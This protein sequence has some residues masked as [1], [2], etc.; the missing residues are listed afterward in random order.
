MARKKKFDYFNAFVQISAHAVTYAEEMVKWLEY[1]YEEG[2]S[3]KVGKVEGSLKAYEKFHAIEEASDEITHEIASNLVTEFV[4]PI[5]REDILTL[6]S[7][8][9]SV[10]DHVDEVLQRMYMYNVKNVSR[11]VVDMANIVLEAT[12]ALH[13]ACERFTDYKQPGALR[14]WIVK[15]NDYEDAGDHAYIRSMHELY[16]RAEESDDPN[17]KIDAFGMGGVLSALENCCDSAED[18]GDTMLMVIMKNS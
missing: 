6:A 3:G 9:D 5:E 1:N 18:A 10:V 16:K 17:T 13:A 14:E 15:V 7:E 11:E 12:R 2:A 4:T 8:L